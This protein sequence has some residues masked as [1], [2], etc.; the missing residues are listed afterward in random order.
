MV[1]L[2]RV[3][4]RALCTRPQGLRIIGVSAPVRRAVTIAGAIPGVVA[5][6]LGSGPA[7]PASLGGG[8]ACE[9]LACREIGSELDSAGADL[10]AFLREDLHAGHRVGVIAPELDLGRRVATGRWFAV[11]APLGHIG[12]P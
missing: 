6:D 3:I 12:E 2:F 1:H 9:G 5:G 7:L 11:P 4:A 8:K 10:D